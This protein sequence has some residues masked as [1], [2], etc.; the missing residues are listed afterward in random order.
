MREITERRLEFQYIPKE[1]SAEF[2]QYVLETYYQGFH[3][4][5]HLTESAEN[6]LYLS[7]TGV[8]YAPRVMRDIKILMEYHRMF[9]AANDL[10]NWSQPYNFFGI[11]NFPIVEVW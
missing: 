6:C 11:R 4:L 1:R 2:E 3:D 9:Y 8:Y 7:P 5:V 10:G